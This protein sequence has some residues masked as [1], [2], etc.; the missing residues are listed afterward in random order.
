MTL[1]DKVDTIAD[2]Q[3][4][5]DQTLLGLIIDFVD[6]DGSGKRLAAHLQWV[7]DE[8]N[9]GSDM[10]EPEI[11]TSSDSCSDSGTMAANSAVLDLERSKLEDPHYAAAVQAIKDDKQIIH[12]VAAAQSPPQIVD[13][14]KHMGWFVDAVAEE[15]ENR[16]NEWVATA[17]LA[18]SN[19]SKLVV[20]YCTKHGLDINVV[21][22]DDAFIDQIILQLK[23]D[24]SITNAFA[25]A[26]GGEEAP[27][28][29]EDD[30]Y[31]ECLDCE[32]DFADEDCHAVDK[33]FICQ[34]C[35]ETRMATG[36]VQETVT[37]NETKPA[38]PASIYNT[39]IKD[40]YGDLDAQLADMDANP[41][42]AEPGG[43]D[44]IH[45]LS[46]KALVLVD[47]L[48]GRLAETEQRYSLLQTTVDQLRE[49]HDETARRMTV[50]ETELRKAKKL[51]GSLKA[52][53]AHAAGFITKNAPRQPSAKRTGF[54][55][56]AETLAHVAEPF[57]STDLPAK[58]KA[59]KK[60]A[61][62]K[63]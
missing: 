48:E 60:P 27:P 30:G 25:Y 10:N 3:G 34:G 50:A 45:G 4:W 17:K 23:V 21:E 19:R 63:R 2:K 24:Q 32:G 47:S 5:R 29:E 36:A 7:A 40:E 28:A 46:Q 9:K 37:D 31:H 33:G 18:I 6:A 11:N 39:G 58:K 38:K 42:G 35:F 59:A 54:L 55:K 57:S 13:N 1:K 26:G 22:N 43:P 14:V 41:V 62:K 61:K 49:I 44:D 56:L 52:H 16:H 12:D 53:I 51:I 8:D 20:S 15:I